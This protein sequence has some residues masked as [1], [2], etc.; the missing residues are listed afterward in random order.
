MSFVIVSAPDVLYG[1][2]ALSTEDSVLHEQ[3][4]SSN[5][6]SHSLTMSRRR[7]RRDVSLSLSLHTNN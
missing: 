3:L 7:R 5:Q 4:T 6:V 1:P 2:T